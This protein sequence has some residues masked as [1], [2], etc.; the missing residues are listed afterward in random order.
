MAKGRGT[1]IERSPGVWRLRVYVG[2]D[3][4][5]QPT[6]LSRTYRGGRHAGYVPRGDPGG[7]PS[8]PRRTSP[9]RPG[10]RRSACSSI[11]VG[12]GH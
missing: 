12:S 4:K 11:R 5:E 2:R 6:Q 7:R 3:G 1:M 8:S 10:C 9:T